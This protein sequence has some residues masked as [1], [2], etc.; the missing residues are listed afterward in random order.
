MSRGR[1][2]E[3]TPTA[4]IG[5]RRGILAGAPLVL[6]GAG[7]V[8]VGALGLALTLLGG[9]LWLA[10]RPAPPPAPYGNHAACVD[11]VRRFDEAPCLGA[12][13]ECSALPC[14]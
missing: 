13:A 2:A 14:R 5:S 3:D 10:T 9:G 12:E 1:A 4:P 7:L 8:A 11:Y 6:A